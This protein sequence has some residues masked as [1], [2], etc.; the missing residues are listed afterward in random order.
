MDGRLLTVST[1]GAALYN[2]TNLDSLPCGKVDKHKATPQPYWCSSKHDY[3]DAC[4][5]KACVDPR[6]GTTRV[7]FAAKGGIYGLVIPWNNVTPHLQYICHGNLKVPF[8]ACLGIDKTYNIR[9]DSTIETSRFVRPGQDKHRGSTLLPLTPRSF[10]Y[11]NSSDYSSISPPLFDE[12]SNRVFTL[13]WCAWTVVDYV[14]HPP[15]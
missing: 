1:S 3:S 13:G 15:G 6:T 12:R 2:I 9:R 8:R 14:T 11:T 7:A 5:S 4:V 10:E